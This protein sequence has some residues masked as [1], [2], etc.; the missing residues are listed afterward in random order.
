MNLYRPVKP[1]A[2][3]QPFGANP[4]YYAKF[5]DSFGN[6][7]KGHDGIDYFA[8]HGTKV[9][10][11]HDGMAKFVTDSHGGEGFFIRSLTQEEGGFPVTMYWHLVG[12]TDATY[13]SPL[14]TD[15]KEYPVTVGTFLGYA[16]NTGAPY[17]SS[18]DHLHFGLFFADAK[19]AI[20]NQSNGFDG[21]VDPQPYMQT[22]FAEDVPQAVSLY[23][24]L[25]WVLGRIISLNK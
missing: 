15:G 12:N 18:G 11:A 8:P 5:H 23:Q 14:S 19:G 16:D 25:L 24:K 22:I 7:L 2:I 10:A 13:P 21:R 9:Y 4:D 3:N 1:G 6:P 17:E 20:L